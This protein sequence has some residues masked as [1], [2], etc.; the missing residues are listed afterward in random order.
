MA[1]CIKHIFIYVSAI[2]LLYSGELFAQDIDI[3][4]VNKYS[5]EKLAFANICLENPLTDSKKY[6]MTG[7]NGSVAVRL[8]GKTI[9]AISYVGYENLIDTISTSR[10]MTFK[11]TPSTYQENEFVVTA[12]YSPV[13]ADQSIYKVKVIDINQISEK[14]ASN[15][16]EL[17]GTELNIR[18]SQDNSLGSKMSIQG[19]SGEHIKLLIDGVPIIGRMDGNID[20]SQINLHHVDHVEIV[21]GPMSV[22]YGSN[23][24][25][26]ALNIITK[27]SKM[28]RFS[29]ALDAYY[30]SVG[31]Y[32]FSGM[33]AGKKKNH[34]YSV[35]AARNFFSGFSLE[36]STRSKQWNPKRQ[37]SADA[38]YIFDL[39]NI[40]FKYASSLFHE[41]LQDKGDLMVPYF[42]HAF[43]QYFATIRFT[44]KLDF[45]AKL[46]NERFFNL[47]L[48]YSTFE[49]R[50]FTFFNDLTSLE[51]NLTSN[52]SD[53]DTSLFDAI[54]FRGTFSKSHKDSRFN[55]QLGY[56]IHMENGSGKR[57]L[58]QKQQIGDYAAFLSI[59]Y[60]PFPVF[61]IQPG[62]RLSHNTRYKA[63]IVHSLNVKWQA[64]ENTVI[65][66]SYAR[67][68]RAPSLKE[69]Y[70]YFVDVNHH[71]IG[72]DNLQAEYSYN[73][74][75]SAAYKFSKSKHNFGIETSL[76][77]NIIE[78]I[79]T[80]ASG[81]ATRYSYINVDH[82]KTH[83]GQ[84]NFS[85]QLHP[86]FTAKT[87]VSLTGRYNS[88]RDEYPALSDYT[89]SKDLNASMRY[90]NV[91][92]K[93]Y[94]SLYYKYNGILPQ[95]YINSEG[96]VKEGFITDYH[97]M[98]LSFG[99]NFLK[100]KLEVS[101]GV[102]NLFNNT[103]IVGIGGSGG[104]HSGDDGNTPVAWGRSLF[105]K[106]GYVFNRY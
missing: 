46:R 17:L 15:L 16:N 6:Y 52:E 24:L 10:D 8:E 79:I 53:H 103:N 41:L 98:D 68:F 20:L 64:A 71:I 28:A 37:Y 84:L 97:H 1:S 67:G 92:Y 27:E 30:E 88:F 44:N 60:A 36:D 83:G 55:Y 90:K 106:L 99:R 75:L 3:S 95:F 5:G 69:L 50:K 43:D 2:V 77:K 31:M 101:A 70:L 12:Q 29:T 82:Y 62:V 4:V 102:K 76:F 74:N 85:Y 48:S 61:S 22:I 32:N 9:V 54:L 45:S 38:Y 58:N 87:G 19:L 73:F 66:A 49:R 94:I 42:E 35:S 63:P 72:N 56:D 18:I 11:L 93:F 14:G 39:T 86:R 80:L 105:F 81:D 34:I 100:D 65:R 51:Q 57:I 96:D 47:L 59:K 91:K 78:N 104:V 25:A 21:E 7:E 13:K 23:A 40:K 33:L 26:G 89:Y